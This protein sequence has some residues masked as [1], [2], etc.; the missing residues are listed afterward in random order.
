[1]PKALIIYK[2]LLSL[3]LINVL[4]IAVKKLLPRAHLEVCR[5]S[6]EENIAYCSKDGQIL[7]F[8][9]RPMTPKEK[10]EKVRAKWREVV[11]LAVSG[12]LDPIQ[13]DHPQV[14]L[15]HY[16]SLKKIA[17]DHMKRPRDLDTVCGEWH[18]GA[19]GT[20]KTTAVRDAHPDAYIKSRDKWWD[21][22]N[23]EPVVILD[24]MS[25][26]HKCLG[27][28]LK[29]WG[30]KWTFKAEE[31]GGYKWL[32]PE[33][34]IVTSQYD[35]DDIFDDAETR[36]ALNRRYKKTHYNQPLV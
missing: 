2:A 33:L 22:Y 3:S 12:D 24:D 7:E 15:A 1:M 18:Y 13:Q 4:L 29:D 21:G 6:S 30:D 36:A 17:K 14:Y 10:G 11:D 25:P 32:R 35:V 5:G 34:F 27:D 16:S 9:E 20:G 28:Y 23:G 19:A 8:G 31:K 26:F